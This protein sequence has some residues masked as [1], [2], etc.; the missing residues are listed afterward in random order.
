MDVVIFAECNA[1]YGELV[2]ILFGVLPGLRIKR[3]ED[4]GHYHFDRRYNAAIVAVNGAK[5]MEL[6]REYRE[7]YP[8]MPVVWIT[9]DAYFAG[10][11]IRSHVFDFIV[12]PYDTARF[13]ETA[14]QLASV[15]ACGN[16]L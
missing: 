12:R 3:E 1:E 4:D 9:D 8:D 16:V 2:D 15:V 11:A 5:G 13:R 6:V 10:T 14:E 7:R